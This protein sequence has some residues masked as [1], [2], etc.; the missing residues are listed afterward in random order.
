MDM[1][2]IELRAQNCERAQENKHIYNI[3]EAKYCREV[4]KFNKDGS[5]LR[6]S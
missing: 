3:S 4:C 6:E 5:C 1:G 2:D